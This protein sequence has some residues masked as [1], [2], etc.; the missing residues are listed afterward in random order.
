MNRKKATFNMRLD[1]HTR[2][3][4]VSAR[5]GIDMVTLLEEIL[6][7]SLPQIEKYADQADIAKSINSAV[8][9]LH[10]KNCGGE[11]REDPSTIYSYEGSEIPA[12]RCHKCGQ[13]IGGDAEIQ[14][15]LEDLQF[16]S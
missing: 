9:I 15:S 12:I 7:H 3:K 16:R 10:H 6:E 14:E 11:L 4:V 2:M 1:L 5:L 8:V 13:E